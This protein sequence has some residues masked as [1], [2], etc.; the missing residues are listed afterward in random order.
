MVFVIPTEKTE[1][2]PIQIGY[3]VLTPLWASALSFS[4]SLSAADT[5][6]YGLKLRTNTDPHDVPWLRLSV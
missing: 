1:K 6:T 2:I 3:D 4:L 5:D